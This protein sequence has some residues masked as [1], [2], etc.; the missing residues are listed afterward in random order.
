MQEIDVEIDKLTNSIE[1]TISGEVFATSVVSLKKNERGFNVKK[2]VFNW[3]KE[4]SYSER[5]VFKLVTEENPK[6]I[7]GLISIENKY[8]HIFMHLLENAY[9]NKGSEKLYAGV[10][11]N[12]VAFACRKSLELGYDGVVSFVSKTKLINHYEKTLGAK[13][14]AGNQMFIDTPEALNLIKRYFK[15]EN[16]N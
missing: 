2:W 12:L 3:N 5:E 10:A 8:D 1:N 14:F 16:K 11:G 9:F 13:L 6:V 15:D 4:L 7:Q